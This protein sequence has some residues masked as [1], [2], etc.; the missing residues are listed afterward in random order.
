M[1]EFTIAFIG[2]PSSGKSSIINSLIGKRILESGICR[3]TTE[4]NLLDNI[5]DDDDNNKFKV[6]AYGVYA[7][8]YGFARNL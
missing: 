7:E 2:L 6:I 3:T 4:Y 5:I 8:G 1:S